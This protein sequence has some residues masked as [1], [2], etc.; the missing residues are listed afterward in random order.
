MPWPG[1]SSRK[2]WNAFA[3]ARR[4]AAAAPSVVALR[5]HFETMRQAVLADGSLDAEAATR[6]LVNKLLHD[7][8]EALRRA[9]AEAP[10]PGENLEDSLR[11]LFALAQDERASEE[12][13]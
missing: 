2:S 8:S 3:A 9:A 5:Q 12:D 11:Q 7:P 13:K 10:Q 1:L 6:L 4:S